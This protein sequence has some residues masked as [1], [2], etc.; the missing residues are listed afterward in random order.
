VDPVDCSTDAPAMVQDLRRSG[1]PADVVVVTDGSCDCACIDR[2]LAAGASGIV[3]KDD[4]PEQLAHALRSVSAGYAVAPVRVAEALCGPSCTSPTGDAVAGGPDAARIRLLTERERDVLR[5][6]MTGASNA[7]IARSL[8]LGVGTV[9]AHVQHLLAKLE[10]RNR[11]QAVIYAYEVGF[12]AA[13][14]RGDA[15]PAPV[16]A[17]RGPGT[18]ASRRHRSTPRP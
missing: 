16:P 15:G 17:P 6:L 2:V 3:L 13:A 14:G 8:H 4:G 1:C 5:S 7:E 9:K 18:G 10:V 11:Q 12:G